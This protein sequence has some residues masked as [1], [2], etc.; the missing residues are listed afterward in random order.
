MLRAERGDASAHAMPFALADISLAQSLVI[1]ATAVVASIIGGMAGYGTGLLLPLVLVPIIGAEATVPVLGVSALFTNTSRAIALRRALDWRRVLLILPP[2]MPTVI[3]AA[4]LFARLN[5]RSAAI[6]I[7]LVLIA[8]VPVRYALKRLR[9]RLSA[10]ATVASGAVYG[11]VT[12][13]STGAGVLLI[14]I[15]MASGLSGAAVIATDA[16]ISI[17]IG[18]AKSMTFGFNSALPPPLFVFALLVGLSTVPGS[19]IAQRIL[20]RMPV[21]IQ[22]RM[23]D[24]VVILG[25]L[26]MV[27]SALRR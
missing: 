21:T 25:G 8:L 12:G 14:S 24:A 18:L 13:G 27:V 23:L 2:A 9:Y 19:F 22:T 3:L 11:L 17:G 15:L 20:A 1:F 7:G 26:M 5:N 6:V 10:A 4:T 16:V